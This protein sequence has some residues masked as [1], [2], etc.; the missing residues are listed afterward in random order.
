MGSPAQGSAQV[1]PETLMSE[2]G[3]KRRWIRRGAGPCSPACRL[4]RPYQL[5]DAPPPPEDPPPPENPPPEDPPP[6]PP[7]DQRPPLPVEAGTMAQPCRL[8]NF[9]PPGLCSTAR[10]IGNPMSHNPAATKP[11]YGGN[12]TEG[13]IA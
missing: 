13:K 4:G 12:T 7:D 9:V 3:R 6:P 5:L 10:R 8:R 2:R 11:P 1:V